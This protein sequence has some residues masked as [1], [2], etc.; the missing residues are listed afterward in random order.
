ML[1]SWQ[2]SDRTPGSC[3]K[4]SGARAPAHH[5][6]YC[7]ALRDRL[8]FLGGRESV[9][10]DIRGHDCGRH[11]K[12]CSDA[13]WFKGPPGRSSMDQ[14]ECHTDTR[15]VSVPDQAFCCRSS[16]GQTPLGGKTLSPFLQLYAARLTFTTSDTVRY[17]PAVMTNSKRLAA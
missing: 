13:I 11:R 17:Q 8:C 5:I 10:V 3:A 4:T 2:S 9:P 16:T 14:S 1:S 12:K 6:H 7:S 15:K